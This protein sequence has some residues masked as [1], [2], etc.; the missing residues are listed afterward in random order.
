MSYKHQNLWFLLFHWL[1]SHFRHL[2]PKNSNNFIHTVFENHSIMDHFWHFWI[3]FF[4]LKCNRTVARFARDV[5]WNFFCDFQTSWCEVISILLSSVYVYFTSKNSQFKLQ[6]Y[7]SF[8]KKRRR[9]FRKFCH[10][11]SHFWVP[12]RVGADASTEK[13]V[14]MMFT[15]SQKTIEK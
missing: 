14:V 12:V 6:I 13:R 7:K 8:W 11:R 2:G 9:R 5:K 10:H 15:V 3:K 4:P 1:S